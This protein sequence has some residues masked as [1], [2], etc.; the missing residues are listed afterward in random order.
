[1]ARLDQIKNLTES[2]DALAKARHCNIATILV[3]GKLRS[4]SGD[5]EE[6]D[7]IE[8]LYRIIDSI[9]LRQNSLAEVRC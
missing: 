5:N 6:R 3:A 9:I 8:K 1:M 4:R 2:G 7:E